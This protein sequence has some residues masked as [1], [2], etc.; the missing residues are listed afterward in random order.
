MNMKI[1]QLSVFVS[2]KP[3]RLADITKILADA[4]V[5]I[6]AISVA[7]TSDFGILRL[8]VDK[9]DVA[10]KALKEASL[11]VSLTD[12]IGICID[13]VKG[14][15]SQILAKLNS[16]NVSVEYVYAF[17]SRQHGKAYIILRV[18][19]DDMAIKVLSKENVEYLTD[20]DVQEM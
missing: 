17:V 16:R 6:R 1:K 19:N 12:V 8:I 15:L 14:R 9:P 3:G 7:D 20:S 13:D 18:D 10:V 11:T 4:D 5:D 2:N